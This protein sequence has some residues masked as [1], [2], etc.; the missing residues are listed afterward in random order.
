MFHGHVHAN[1]GVNLPMHMT[2]E[3]GTL[4]YNAYGYQILDLPDRV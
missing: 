1:Y 4:I 3:S 2:H